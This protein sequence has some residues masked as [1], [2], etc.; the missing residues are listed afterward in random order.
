MPGGRYL[1]DRNPLLNVRRLREKN[2]KQERATW[3]RY[4]ATMAAMEKAQAL[5][6]EAKDDVGRMRWIRMRFALFLA[7]ARAVS[8][9]NSVAVFL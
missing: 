3:E 1:L 6:V 7:E 9:L 5:A 2:K 4:Q 8:S